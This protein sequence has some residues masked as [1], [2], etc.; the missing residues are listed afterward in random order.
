MAKRVLR[1]PPWVW[2]LVYVGSLLVLMG[3]QRWDLMIAGIALVSSAFLLA[4]YLAQRPGRSRAPAAI[5]RWAMVGLATFYGGLAIVALVL[6]G[7][8]YALAVLLG[9]LIPA[10]AISL[11]FA[12]VRQRTVAAERSLEDRSADDEDEQLPGVGMD[13]DTPLGDTSELSDVQEDPMVGR[14]RRLRD[15]RR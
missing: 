3:S 9:G 5:Y 13:D 2:L 7:P 1:W 12:T 15:V 8:A 11:L 4:V 6:L 14:R 10:T